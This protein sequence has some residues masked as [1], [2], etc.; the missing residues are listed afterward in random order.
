MAGGELNEQLGAVELT[1]DSGG[2][3][4]K[5]YN[6]MEQAKRVLDLNLYVNRDSD[7][8]AF[9]ALTAALEKSEVTSLRLD[10][11]SQERL[12]GLGYKETVSTSRLFKILLRIQRL[13]AMR[14]ITVSVPL[15]EYTNFLAL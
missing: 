11:C 13:P 1:R 14:L 9:L 8:S 4:S 7:I 5:L 10:L 6:S 15:T 2:E 12:L 3:A